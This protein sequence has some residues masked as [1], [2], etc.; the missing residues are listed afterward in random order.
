ML[1]D[2]ECRSWV[3]LE[4]SGLEV[5]VGVS[6]QVCALHVFDLFDFLTPKLII[7]RAVMVIEFM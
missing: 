7:T 4:L 1:C 6:G 3:Y 2:S 5:C